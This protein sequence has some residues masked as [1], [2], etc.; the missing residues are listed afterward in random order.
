MKTFGEALREIIAKKKLSVSA[1]A[2]ELGFRS[3]TALF[4]ILG[5][6]C[7]IETSRKCMEAAR[8]SGLLALTAQEAEKLERALEVS[9][10]GKR[11]Y[12]MNR[13]LRGMLLASPPPPQTEPFTVEGIDGVRTMQEL[14][15]ACREMPRLSVSIL[16]RC[17][18][19]ILLLLHELA[20]SLT[21]RGI[22]HVLAIDANNLK[23]LQAFSETAFMLFLPTYALGVL[24]GGEGAKGD[25]I[26]RSSMIVLSGDNARGERT[27]VQLVYVGGRHYV[28]FKEESG[29]LFRHWAR[30]GRQYAGRVEDLKEKSFCTCDLSF[31]DNYVDMCERVM[32][33]ESGREILMLKPDIPVMCIPA[34][35]F[36][37][38]ITDVMGEQTAQYAR[39]VRQ[40]MDIHGTRHQNFLMKKKPTHLVVDEAAM[41]RFAQT[42][43]CTDHVYLARAFTPQ[44]RCTILRGLK[45]K[46][47]QD[48][49]FH[50]WFGKPGM[51]T[52]GREVT[53]YD[54]YGL[55]LIKPNT[56]WRLDGDHNEMLLT[57]AF[58]ADSMKDFFHTEVLRKEVLPQSETARILDALIALAG[59]CT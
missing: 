23:D 25:W 43:R 11:T 58:L 32:R 37:T 59:E 33:V 44:E 38:S 13:V 52:D 28:G 29:G 57:S 42:G 46:T 1:V 49:G 45:E 34:D 39:Q 47:Q 27:V 31:P 18:P 3:K 40:L 41:R 50:L 24:R 2:M 4:R 12:A 17:H 36:A 21:M 6:E 16:G 14:L 20:G 26:F 48:A 10:V 51:N 22:R 15:C 55:S 35:I 19:D 8:E 5:D 53:V 7:R 56:S 9:E 54:E 30:I